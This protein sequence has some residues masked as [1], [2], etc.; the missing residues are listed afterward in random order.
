MGMSESQENAE[1]E[2]LLD[3]LKRAR[4]FDFTGYKRTSLI[5]RIQKRMQTAGSV[6]Y[7]DY[8]D[9]LEVH[10]EEFIQLF[11]TILINVTGF[12]RD[13]KAWQYLDEYV[14][15]RIISRKNKGEIIRVWSA[16]CASGEEAYTISMMMAEHLGTEA[17]KERVKVYATDL[18]EEALVKA[19][20]AGYT[21]GEV[22]EIPKNLLEKYFEVAGNRYNF[23]K[24]LRRSVIFGRHDLIQ[25][26]P[27][28]RVD[29]LICRNVL[30]YFNTEAQARILARLNYALSET[31]FLYLGKAELLLTHINLFTPVDIKNRVFSKAPSA[32]IRDRLLVMAHN[33]LDEGNNH[34]FG[35]GR[36]RDAAFDYGPVAQVVVD[37][38][39]YL[40]QVNEKARTLFGLSQRDIGRPF[41]DLEVSYRPVE[42]RASIEQTYQRNAPVLLRDIAMHPGSGEAIFLDVLLHPLSVNG[43]GAVG[44]SISFMNVSE[45]KRLL[46]QL[47]QSNQELETAMEELQSTNE[48]LETTNEELQSTIEELETT[49]EEL[50][51]TN[52]E[53]ETMNEELQS[54]NEELETMNDEMTQRTNEL[55]QVN[56]FLESILTSL[57]GSVVV[58]DKDF[59]VQVWNRKA[60]DQWGLRSEEVQ[61]V[62]FFSLDIG[63]P[64]DRL[65]KP[66]R[67]IMTGEQNQIEL[68]MEGTNRRGKIIL[69]GVICTPLV[70][71]E[72]Q[73]R[74]VIIVAEQRGS[75]KD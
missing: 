32:N 31:G 38:N 23:Q 12:F 73:I 66:I 1:F 49:N 6:N 8:L 59:R 42:L 48:E 51:S 47:E 60:E 34:L 30:M 40:F 57:K 46:L 3:Y 9:H 64:V 10:P 39:G 54:T 26:A 43:V 28:S 22:E 20:L 2:A 19:R 55:N 11:N 16:G 68:E 17:F 41:Q 36:V 74:G 5:R 7:Q 62:N 18:D 37:A 4:G 52:E 53:L 56:A 71:L 13:P 61:N 44:V 70:G 25:D 67:A 21:A 72:K 75:S 69:C 58:I 29:L 27:I 65:R 24:D 63:L 35:Q 15:P 50:Q 33:G 45:H 14:L